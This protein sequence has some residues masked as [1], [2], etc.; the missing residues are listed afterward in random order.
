MLW[1]LYHGTLL[2]VT[3]TLGTLLRLPEH[4]PGPLA[5]RPDRADF[6]LMMAGWLFFRETN[7]HFL[8]RFLR[9]RRST[10]RRRSARSRLYLFV[11]GGDLVA[12]A[13]RRRPV[14]LWR[15]RAPV[16]GRRAIG[17]GRRARASPVEA[18]T[19]GAVCSR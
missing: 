17:L 6:V 8:F 16:A 9:C 7:P 15:E 4:W 13:L 3:R 5:A 14:A 19:V 1:G 2:V 10:A 11:T 18:A 12:A